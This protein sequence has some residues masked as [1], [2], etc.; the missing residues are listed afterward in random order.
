MVPVLEPIF[1]V[2][3]I[4]RARPI[5]IGVPYVFRRNRFEYLSR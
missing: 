2:I 3:R 1:I 4:S 5:R